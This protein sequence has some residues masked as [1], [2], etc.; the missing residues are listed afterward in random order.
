[1]EGNKYQM[2]VFISGIFTLLAFSILVFRVHITK[3]TEHL[4]YTWIAFL[5]ISQLLLVI[6]GII[7]RIERIYILSTIL[8]LGIIYILYTK[9]NYEENS[10]VEEGL[11]K[12]H[13]LS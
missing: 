11:I 9:I 7:N 5:L 6:Y 3:R 12:K 13:I 1:M 2:I 10:I 8:L 4:S